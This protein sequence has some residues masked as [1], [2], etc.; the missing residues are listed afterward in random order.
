MR[1]EGSRRRIIKD[2]G[3]VIRMLTDRGDTGIV[4]VD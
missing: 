3:R 1:I 2:I 4:L